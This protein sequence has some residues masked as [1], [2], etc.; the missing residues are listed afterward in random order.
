MVAIWFRHSAASQAIAQG[1]SAKEVSW[2]LGHL[3]NTVPRNVYVQ[4]IREQRE[5]GSASAKNGGS[6]WAY[7]GSGGRKRVID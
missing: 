5:K 3:N 6:L 4:A 7:A 1:D 2:Q